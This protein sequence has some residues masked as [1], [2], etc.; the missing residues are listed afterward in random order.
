LHH[1]TKPW[2]DWLA[3]LLNLLDYFAWEYTLTKFG[4]IQNPVDHYAVQSS[5]WY[6]R[7]KSH[8]WTILKEWGGR[9]DLNKYKSNVLMYWYCYGFEMGRI[10]KRGQLMP[11]TLYYNQFNGIFLITNI[12]KKIFQT[13]II[14]LAF[15][16]IMEVFPSFFIYFFTIHRYHI[17]I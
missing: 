3:S 8:F 12:R 17:K 16:L 5:S 6:G 11:S 15:D 1:P 4:Q 2:L 13:L 10:K 9:I 14:W 7:L